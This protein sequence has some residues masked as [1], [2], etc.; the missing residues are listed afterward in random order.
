MAFAAVPDCFI[1]TEH[2]HHENLFPRLLSCGH[3]F[4]SNC[5]E[6]L[7]KNNS[8]SCPDCRKTTS[9]PTGVTGLTKNYEILKMVCTTTQE[10]EE[11]IAKFVMWSI[12][13]PHGAWTA[14]M[15]CARLQLAFTLE[16][17]G[18]VLTKLFP[19]SS[20]LCPFSVPNIK[21]SSACSMKNAITWSVGAVLLWRIRTTVFCL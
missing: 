14:I 17:R 18:V 11:K 21:N 8:I 9:V 12:L 20:W 7:L 3:T 4:C 1:C 13:Q 19:W 15:I 10:V 5:L 2:Y 16:A 6:K